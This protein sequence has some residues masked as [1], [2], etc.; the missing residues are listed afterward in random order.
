[1]N[2]TDESRSASNI[3]RLEGKVA[4]VTGA[5]SGIGEATAKELGRLGASVV[6]V[7]R[8]QEKLES[9]V[10]SIDA[11]GGTA[12]SFVADITEPKDLA[13]MVATATDT[14]GRLDYAVNN[15]GA[16]GRGAFLDIKVEDFDHTMNTNVRAVFL[17]MQAEI[18]ALLESGGGAIVNTASVGGLVGVPNLA[19]YVAS[20]HA[21]VGLTKSVALEFATKGIRVN[22]IAPGGTETAM[23]SS[24]TKEQKDTLASY[25]AMKRLAEP[26]EIARGIVYLLA[27][28]TFTT[29]ITMA[30]D[31]G[32]SA[33]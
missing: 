21:V 9:I 17:A 18:P 28:A 7:A 3:H 1:M 11:A 29:G 13:K 24:G 12:I 8:R 22:A 25:S 33:S 10:A 2:K 6:L 20:K 26:D 5:S 31:G 30:A 23:I 16:T 4:I 14:Y 15:A 27:D 19:P 32:Q